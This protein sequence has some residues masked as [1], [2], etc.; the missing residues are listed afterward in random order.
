MRGLPHRVLSH[1]VDE[2][3][4]ESTDGR[5]T[6]Q[7]ADAVD[8]SPGPVSDVLRRLVAR[9]LITW[10]HNDISG[11]TFRVWPTPE[12][13][14]ELGRDGH[15]GSVVPRARPLPASPP[16]LPV[17]GPIGHLDFDPEG[18]RA[19]ALDVAS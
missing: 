7:I 14:A 9:G 3:L 2:S 12:G 4:V 8:A 5:V 15:T 13:R 6:T 11:R 18:A 10:D 16:A 19:R 1:I 17:L